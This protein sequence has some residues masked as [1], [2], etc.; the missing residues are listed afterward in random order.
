[1]P[2]RCNVVR[3]LLLVSLLALKT[4]AQSTGN[5]NNKTPQ[6][7]SDLSNWLGLAAA[8]EGGAGW[9][10]SS[11]LQSAAFAGVKLGIPTRGFQAKRQLYTLT[12][13]LGYDRTRQRDGFS[14]EVSVMLPVWRHPGPQKDEKKNYLRLYA[15][16]GAG[17]RWGG[18][19]GAYG[20]AKVMVAFFSDERLTSS[21]T[22]WSPFFEVQRR[23]PF[24]APLNGD[25]R[26][27][28]GMMWAICNHCGLD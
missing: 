27:T 14:T 18:G 5:D 8:V 7:P 20:S 26:I 15:E 9:S 22:K 28:L 23:F 25:T 19:L 3:I 1:M 16:P 13:D 4:Q 2:I 17:Y 24:A 21:K 10:S 11:S 6:S 12:L